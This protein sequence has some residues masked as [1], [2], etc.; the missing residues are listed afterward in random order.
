MTTHTF[1]GSDRVEARDVVALVTG[2]GSGIGLGCAR[3][4]LRAGARVAINDRASDAL[5]RAAAALADEGLPASRIAAVCAD[6]TDA[7]T[8]ARMFAEVRQR[9][10]PVG[11]LVNNAAVSGGRLPLAEIADEQWDRMMTANLRGVYLCTRQALPDMVAKRWGRV[12]NIASV[13]GVSGKL[14]ASAHYAAAK[15]G[16]VAFTRRVAME[17]APHGVAVNAVA[18]G[19]IADTGFTRAITGPLLERYLAGI[20]AHRAGTVDEVAQLAAFLCSEHA[21][22][23]VGQT[24]VVD[25]GASA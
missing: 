9:W 2:A 17:A 13:A 11:A 6:V 4:L 8:V 3:A 15:G 7:G 10:G 16:V 18:P 25:G 23:I 12:V 14:L 20:P 22:Y 24:V 1:R 21:G 5:D 19:L